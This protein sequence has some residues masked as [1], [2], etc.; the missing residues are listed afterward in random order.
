MFSIAF[1]LKRVV[2]HEERSFEFWSSSL[3]RRAKE[4]SHDGRI[5]RDSV[6][7]KKAPGRSRNSV[8]RTVARPT[9]ANACKLSSLKSIYIVK[10]WSLKLDTYN[11][12]Q[13]QDHPIRIPIKTHGK[14]L[15]SPF[16]AVISV[17]WWDIWYTESYQ[18]TWINPKQVSDM[19]LFCSFHIHPH[20]VPSFQDVSL[21]IYLQ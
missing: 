12:Y 10:I 17:K 19:I 2:L 13:P 5:G 7:Q 18:W 16:R 9:M 1:A 14:I 15:F 8:S 6:G 21:V 3:K 4:N 20:F 11:L